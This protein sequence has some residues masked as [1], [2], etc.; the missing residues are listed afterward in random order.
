MKIL[1]RHAM[2]EADGRS[3]LETHLWTSTIKAEREKFAK[4]PHVR[5]LDS[6]KSI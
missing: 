1:R 6:E 2:A 5:S 4:L 3:R